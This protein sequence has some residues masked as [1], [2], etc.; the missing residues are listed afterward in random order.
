MVR[1]TDVVPILRPL[2]PAAPEAGVELAMLR[3]GL[4]RSSTAA[5]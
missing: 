5:A 2:D 1:P 4:I 3:W